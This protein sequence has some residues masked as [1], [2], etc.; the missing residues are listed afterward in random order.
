MQS[1]RKLSLGS[2]V[3][4]TSDIVIVFRHGCGIYHLLKITVQYHF[5]KLKKGI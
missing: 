3:V 1:E 2:H 4:P 5:N